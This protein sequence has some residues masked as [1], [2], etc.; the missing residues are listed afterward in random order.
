MD[1]P[2]TSRAGGCFL[3]GGLLI[4][5]AVGLASGSVMRGVWI[6]L[7]AGIVIAIGLWIADKRKG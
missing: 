6:G 2:S 5:F 7:A 4:G 1:G 3:T